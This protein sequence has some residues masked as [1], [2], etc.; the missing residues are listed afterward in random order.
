MS[1][2]AQMKKTFRITIL[3]IIAAI[4]I[5]GIRSVGAVDRGEIFPCKVDS[6]CMPRFECLHAVTVSGVKQRLDPHLCGQEAKFDDE[7]KKLL[8]RKY[9]YPLTTYWG[10]EE[11][12]TALAELH[13]SDALQFMNDT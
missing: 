4:A 11:H 5:A 9:G 10:E 13:K 6:D 12:Y 8:L 2:F 1:G 7:F 3:A